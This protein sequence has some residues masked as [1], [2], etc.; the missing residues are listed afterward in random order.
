MQPVYRA[1]RS[2]VLTSLLCPCAVCCVS[3]VCSLQSGGKYFV[4]GSSYSTTDPSAF[5]RALDART[6]RFRG[7]QEQC[8][9]DFL[10]SECG[11]S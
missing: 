6:Q 5:K 11:G 3:P 10:Q 9:Y 8:A 2:P 7:Y 4:A 1:V